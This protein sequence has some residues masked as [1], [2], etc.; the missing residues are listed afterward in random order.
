MASCNFKNAK[1]KGAT[2]SKMRLRHCSKEGRKYAKKWNK[3]INLDKTKD[4]ISVFGLSYKQCCDK[5]DKRI[6]E[7][8]ANGNTNKRK[9]RVTMVCIEVPAPADLPEKQRE[10]WFCEL[11]KIMLEFFGPDNMIEGFWHVD[12]IHPYIE[13]ESKK[14]SG[15]GRTVTFVAYPKFKTA[16]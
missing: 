6:A 12:E 16:R 10:A 7:I 1:L 13:P 2:A 14:R 9:D 8:D 3:N 11:S 5:Y 4:N 15:R